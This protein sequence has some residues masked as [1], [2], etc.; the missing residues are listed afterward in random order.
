MK[1]NYFLFI[2][3]LF[4]GNLLA[5]GMD[6]YLS[7][8][9]IEATRVGAASEYST[10]FV[11]WNEDG[12]LTI[13]IK[14]NNSGINID[15]NPGFIIKEVTVDGNTLYGMTT[16]TVFI[17]K[18]SLSDGSQINIT[19]EKR[20][21]KVVVINADPSML[22]VTYMYETFQSSSW[23]NNQLRIKVNDP[24]QS[25]NISSILGYSLKSI[26]YQGDNIIDGFT[27]NYVINP[28]TL[29][30]GENV[31]DVESISLEELRTSEFT[32]DVNGDSNLVEVTLAGDPSLI[33]TGS[34][35]S[36]PIKFSPEFDLPISIRNSNYNEYLY[37]VTLDGKDVPRSD[38]A[39]KIYDI[40]NG[41]KVHVDVDFPEVMVPIRLDFVNPETE[42][43]IKSVNDVHSRI[44]PP[45][46]WRQEGW[47]VPL[48]SVITFEFNSVDFDVQASLNGVMIDRDYVRIAV[49]DETGYDLEVTAIAKDPFKVTLW[50]DPV[51]AHFRVRIG[52]TGEDYISL[53]P[54]KEFTVIEVPRN[55]N[56]LKI[57]PD[58]GWIIESLSV[59]ASEKQSDDVPIDQNCEVFVFLREYPRDLQAVFY[60]D[61]L[62][63]WNNKEIIL[64]PQNAFRYTPLILESG[65]NLIYYNQEDLPFGN[66]TFLSTSEN[67]YD[68]YTYIDDVETE[69]STSISEDLEPG[70]IIKL[71][72]ETPS[73]YTVA[74]DKE[75]Y[76]VVSMYC[77]LIDEMNCPKGDHVNY[78]LKVLSGTRFDIIPED[79]TEVIVS[80]NGV[81]QALQDDRYIVEANAD[82]T[83]KIEKGIPSGAEI[84]GTEETVDVFSLQGI[85][86]LKNV[87][88]TL[89]KDLPS[90]IYIIGGKK[91]TVK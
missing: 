23:N 28:L 67:V 21:E 82:L 68:Y 71:Y 62:T 15:I 53:D 17:R 70:S 76:A 89:I 14:D 83:V 52:M 64:C 61:P 19:A 32:I 54:E 86:V 87:N 12:T 30:A 13:T 74:F 24:Y 8:N 41:G 44:I 72:G 39:Y 7:T 66:E 81:E 5:N 36:S 69:T 85:C 90:G 10:A 47:S 27:K 46:E 11:P 60:I 40:P 45:E 79:V 51:P 80:V 58:E 57:I 37:K 31:F 29:P 2:L 16:S 34:E 56:R 55:R 20:D 25:I 18:G 4:V 88:R 78:D 73:W 42:G 63:T 49:L 91:V 38:N 22:K 65:Y 59:G 3:M 6:V 43:S 35:L 75:A 84:V 50:Y 1:K 33:I 9:N 48:G 77:D 26:K